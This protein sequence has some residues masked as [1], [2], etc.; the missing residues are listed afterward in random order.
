MDSQIRYLAIVSE[1]PDTLAHFY[2]NYFGMRELGRSDAGDVALTDGFYN[3][4]ILKPRDSA[5]EL[6]ISHL[7]I[8]ID[9][10]GQI[11]ARL[12]DFAPKTDICH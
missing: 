11:E 6:G 12:K 1:Q 8:T 9:D 3:I 7:G 10:I 5:A 4:S 2:S